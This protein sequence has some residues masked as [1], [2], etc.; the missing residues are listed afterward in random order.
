[1]VPFP[2]L[3]SLLEGRLIKDRGK[4][5][6]QNPR[7]N[8]AEFYNRVQQYR[9]LLHDLGVRSQ[10]KVSIGHLTFPENAQAAFAVWFLGGIVVFGA[11]AG[12]I[13]DVTLSKETALPKYSED[14]ALPNPKPR[15]EA[16]AVWQ[17]NGDRI[18]RLSH[19][20]CLVNTYA[21]RRM[22]NLPRD[23]HVWYESETM[24]MVGFI[25]NVLLPHYGGYSVDKEN[26]TVRFGDS[27]VSDVQIRRQ[28][29]SLENTDPQSLYVLPE[30]TAFVALGKKVFPFLDFEV[31]PKGIQLSGPAVMNG[32]TDEALT[33][34]VCTE[35]GLQLP[36][37]AI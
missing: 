29:T 4:V 28:W 27:P 31:H 7:L 2:N 15:L 9:R 18:I 23:S 5:F 3:G 1:M 20:N 33:R 34:K 10:S 13:A 8:V 32:Y 30:H 19:Y 16:D 6:V 14:A 36:F 12:T 26:P 21:L 22:L 37:P 25:L 17:I 24:D 35:S 11:K